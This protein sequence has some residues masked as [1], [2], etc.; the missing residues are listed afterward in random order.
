MTTIAVAI[1]GRAITIWLAMQER[2]HEQIYKT[3]T[4][5]EAKRLW[6]K[7]FAIKK[8]KERF[9]CMGSNRKKS[10]IAIAILKIVHFEKVPKNISYFGDT[11]NIFVKLVYDG[12]SV[13]N[14]IL[15]II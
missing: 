13:K 2:S 8:L 11:N 5:N 1:V 15:D 3:N 10:N 7:T 9:N 14:E 6:S 4:K 12:I